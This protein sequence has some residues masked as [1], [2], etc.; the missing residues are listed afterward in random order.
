MLLVHL[1]VAISHLLE[2]MS[3]YAVTSM[4]KSTTIQKC[5]L[6]D[7]IKREFFHAVAVSGQLVSNE[8]LGV[9]LDGNNTRMLRAVLRKS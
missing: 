4:D 6:S 3:T 1:S 8:T 9:K 7:R 5:Y 2:V